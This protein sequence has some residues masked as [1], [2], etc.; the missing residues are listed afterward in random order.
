MSAV[1]NIQYLGWADR[2]SGG[3]IAG[4]HVPGGRSPW[5][6]GDVYRSKLEYGQRN[7]DSVRR[8]QYRLNRVR[9][10]PGSKLP[11]TGYFG[12]MTARKV[13]AYLDHIGHH[14]RANRP[15]HGMSMGWGETNRLFGPH[16]EVHR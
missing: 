2:F 8:L 3:A 15:L 4:L 5:S 10:L 7:S 11:I 12:G 13:K 14:K 16:Y 6:H 1:W 9:G